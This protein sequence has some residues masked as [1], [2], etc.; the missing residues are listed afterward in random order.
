MYYIQKD[1]IYINETWEGNIKYC[2]NSRCKVL[3][4]KNT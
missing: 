2:E 3:L 4:E 1:N